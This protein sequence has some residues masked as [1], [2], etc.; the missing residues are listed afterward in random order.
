M[1]ITLAQHFIENCLLL[2]CCKPWR[3]LYWL[4]DWAD[5][6]TWVSQQWHIPSCFTKFQS[7]PAALLVLFSVS[8]R[9]TFYIPC[10]NYHNTSLEQNRTTMVHFGA[11]NKLFKMRN[12]C[13]KTE[14]PASYCSRL[15]Y[16]FPPE[17]NNELRL[18]LWQLF[19]YGGSA[20][21]ICCKKTKSHHTTR[22][23]RKT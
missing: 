17:Q 18:W 7:M 10:H 16:C 3:L 5:G 4:V 1:K 12:C 20:D 6:K 11:C 22:Y 19:P 14:H 8:L 2:W 13:T 23:D 9:V 21:K 15:Q